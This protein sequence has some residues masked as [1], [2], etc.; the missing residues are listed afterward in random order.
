[1]TMNAPS[2]GSRSFSRKI[3]LGT[4]SPSEKARSMIGN[5]SIT[6]VP[7]MLFDRSRRRTRRVGKISFGTSEKI[8]VCFTCPPG[9]MANRAIGSFGS[10]GNRRAR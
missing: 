8:T 2:R 4:G 10:P 5:S 3:G 7:V 6:V 1:M 9:A